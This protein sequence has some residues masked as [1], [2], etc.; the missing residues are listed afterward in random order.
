MLL[1]KRAEEIVDLVNKTEK[2]FE[3]SEDTISGDI[4]IGAGETDGFRWLL[5][6]ADKIRK[7]HPNIHYHIS[8]GDVIDVLY[9]LDKGIIDFALVFGDVDK[10]KYECITLPPKDTWG[11]LMQK[12]SELA[13][14]EYIS[15][16]DLY[17]KPLIVSRQAYKKT[18]NN[19]LVR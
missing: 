16:E 19:C 17:D 2:E 8:S 18:R 9:N 14:R 10:T 4:Y 11:V 3:Q 6:I 15:P 1:Q 12:D 5:K 13:D 7:E